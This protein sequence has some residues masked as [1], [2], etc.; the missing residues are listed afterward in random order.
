M[1]YPYAASAPPQ[2]R[3]G[4]PLS[5]IGYRSTAVDSPVRLSTEMVSQIVA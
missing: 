4:D 3:T 2:R 5:C 1:T